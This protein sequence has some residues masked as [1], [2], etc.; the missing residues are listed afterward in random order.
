M[1]P[2]AADILQAAGVV[3]G[4]RLRRYADADRQVRAALE[5]TDGIAASGVDPCALA[6]AYRRRV[7]NR[8]RA[9]QVLP[10]FSA[11]CYAAHRARA[12]LR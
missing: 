1:T 6:V 2:S 11:E 4:V 12:V 10:S 5:V 8:L 7:G 9:H 3:S